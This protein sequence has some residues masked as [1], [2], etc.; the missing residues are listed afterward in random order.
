[1]LQRLKFI[2]ITIIVSILI[3]SI[4]ENLVFAQRSG[5]IRILV[6]IDILKLLV[7]PIVGDKGEVLSVIPEGVE[8]HSFILNPSIIRAALD[9]DLMVITGHMEWEEDL[10]K[11]V[12]EEKGIS[13]DSISINLLKLVKNNGTL[14]KINDEENIHG[15]WLLPDNAVLITESLKNM[16]SK[17]KPE[18][19]EEFSSNFA[20]FKSR[21]SSLKSF[22]KGL[23]EKYGLANSKVVIGFYA[24]QYVV[25]ALGLK[26]GAVLVG[27]EE[28][29]KPDSLSRIYKGLESGEY[30]CIIVSDTALLMSN[31]KN[32]LQQISADTGCSIAYVSIV[33]TNG[34]ENYDSIMYYNAGQVYSALLSSRKPVSKGLDIYFLTTLIALIVIVIETLIIVR[35]VR[36]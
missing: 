3:A 32:T 23:S 17:I 21:A 20:S 6:T 7:S 24:E 34:L 19:S 22:L 12:A 11:R 31:V 15:F 2:I 16:L 14:L 18:Y 4:C 29:I 36:K 9:S 25:E 1:M 8:P 26:I 28:V 10:V 13:P 30:S 5:R 33:S 27:E 35:R